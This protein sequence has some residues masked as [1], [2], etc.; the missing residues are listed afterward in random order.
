LLWLSGCLGPPKSNHQKIQG[1]H[2]Y[3]YSI[4]IPH[5]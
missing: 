1:E 3:I 2:I 5:F 4:I